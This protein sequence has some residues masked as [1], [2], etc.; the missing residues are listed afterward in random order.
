MSTIPPA[1]TIDWQ[2]AS[3]D[4]L[5]NQDVY[6][7]LAA[8]QHVFILEQQCFYNDF[9]GL[10]PSAHHVLGWA[11]VDGQ[12]QLVAYLRVLA[13]GAKYAEASIGRVLT[14]AAGRGGGIGRQLLEQ[15]L[16][17]VDSLYPAAP[18]KIGAQRYLERFYASFG[19]VTISEPYDEDG[20]LHVDMRR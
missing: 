6:A 14:S 20:I 3:F 17:Y 16:A 8:R 9:D 12:R 1:T 2:R 18:I 15:G 11:K 7:V 10:D 5:S 19:F 4:Q 13:P